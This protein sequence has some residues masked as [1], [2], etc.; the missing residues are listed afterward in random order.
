MFGQK[1]GLTQEE[2]KQLNYRRLGEY[3]GF[4]AARAVVEAGLEE[5]LPRVPGFKIVTAKNDGRRY[6]VLTVS[7]GVLIP[8]RSAAGLIVALKVRIP[9]EKRRLGQA[10]YFY[11]SSKKK[12]IGG[13]G[14]GARLHVPSFSGDRSIIRITE[15]ELKS[16]IATLRSEVLTVSVPGVRSWKTATS[17]LR[18]N[19]PEKVLI[20][21]DAD[22]ATNEDV[23]RPLAQLIDGVQDLDIPVEVEVWPE[24]AGKGID[25]VF[26]AG[27]G[28][29][30]T[31]LAGEDLQTF[32][33]SLNVPATSNTTKKDSA[34]SRVTI[35]V[36]PHEGKV[37][38]AIIT[39]LATVD[40]IYQRK[41]T[42]VE[43]CTDASQRDGVNRP[44]DAPR[45]VEIS[46]AKLRSII[47]DAVRFEYIKETKEGPEVKVV[48]P[49][50]ACVKAVHQF[51]VYSGVWYLDGIVEAPTIRPDGSIL[52]TAGYDAAT[53]LVYIPSAEFL[54]IPEQA[55]QD[56]IESAKAILEEVVIDFPFVDESHRSAWLASLFTALARHT[57][58]GPTPVFV[59]DASTRGSG[60]SLLA[61]VVSIITTG[62]IMPKIAYAHD[63][64]ETRKVL[65]SVA[66][67]GDRLLCWDNIAGAFGNASLDLAATTTCLKGRDLGFTKAPEFAFHTVMFATGNNIAIL[68]DTTRRVL[69]SR[70]E[71]TEE[72]PEDRT[73]F[74]HTDLLGWVRENRPRLVVAA[75]TILRGWFAAGKPRADLSAW[76]SFQAWSDVIRQTIVWA[77]WPDPAGPRIELRSSADNEN[78]ALVRMMDVMEFRDLGRKGL[79]AAEMIR[80]ATGDPSAAPNSAERN[81]D[82]ELREAIIEFCPTRDGKLPTAA[83]L[84]YRLRHY[85]KRFV[86]GRAI[87]SKVGAHRYTAWFILGESTSRASK[88]E[89]GEHGEDHQPLSYTRELHEESDKTVN[90]YKGMAETSSPSSSSSP[91]ALSLF[92]DY[93]QTPTP[94]KPDPLIVRVPSLDGTW[95]E[96]LVDA[97]AIPR[98]ATEWQDG[99]QWLPIPEGWRGSTNDTKAGDQRYH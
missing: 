19:R 15:G 25:D 6:W 40:G 86:E 58:D 51:K 8:V 77:G 57:F 81:G 23:R 30:I 56:E 54:S 68:G 59:I 87:D 69:I 43:V 76:G 52:A 65:T 50:P 38:R 29:Q 28:D 47:S 37:N 49:P 13:A 63:N 61:D 83:K 53:G 94:S 21:F 31:R 71:T 33:E 85:R 22:F 11:L 82:Q 27:K 91:E 39:A 48:T 45:I 34:D 24:D 92:P 12:K 84:G 1:R 41:G 46:E 95:Q 10:K 26:A 32:R 16:D 64:D 90:T 79:T 73:G 75:L 60:K 80:E 55:T 3:D 20:A 42:L 88:G 62:R 36:T 99:G 35:E 97:C 70:L 96:G 44:V 74:R 17:Y 93:A 67:A 7:E 2:T 14:P 5:H 9:D 72:N 66:M 78:A 18:S 4:K 89:H 98:Q